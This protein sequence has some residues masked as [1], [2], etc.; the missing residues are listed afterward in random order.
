[1]TYARHVSIIVPTLNR[2]RFVELFVRSLKRL[3]F[4][5]K[6]VL[7]DSSEAQSFELTAGDLAKLAPTFPIIHEHLPGLGNA[8]ALRAGLRHAD[9]KYCLFMPDDDIP[10]PQTLER[11]AAFLEVRSDYAAATGRVAI[12]DVE[13]SDVLNGGAYYIGRYEQLTPAERLLELLTS[14]SVVHFSVSRREQFAKRLA[15]AAEIKEPYLGLEILNNCLH[16]IDGKIGVVD[17]LFMVRQNHDS[18]MSRQGFMEWILRD[19]WGDSLR[20]VIAAVSASLSNAQPM[21]ADEARQVV[22]AAVQ[23]YLHRASQSDTNPKFRRLRARMRS[24]PVLQRRVRNIRSRTPGENGAL[25]L[26]ALLWPGSRYHADF[27]P[28]Y[29]AITETGEPL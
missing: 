26:E 23:S 20:R 8:E 28:V 5:G 22:T 1:M 19:E 10:V 14:Y 12:L 27:M 21:P 18:R 2:P 4:G 7:C 17:E 11:C 24:I 15:V 16:V 9:T 3:G 6:L 13:G 29:L 25:T